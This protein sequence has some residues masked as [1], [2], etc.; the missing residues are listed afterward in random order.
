[1]RLNKQ[2]L[3]YLSLTF[4][5]ILNVDIAIRSRE[6]NLNEQRER[7]RDRRCDVVNVNFSSKENLLVLRS[8]LIQMILILDIF[9]VNE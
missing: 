2:W 1:M 9:L 8:E 7:E 4:Q 3:D 5:S 6:L